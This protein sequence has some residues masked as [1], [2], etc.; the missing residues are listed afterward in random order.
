[1]PWLLCYPPGLALLGLAL[2]TLGW[3]GQRI[4]DHPWCRR[5]RFDLFGVTEPA[6][7]PECGSDLRPGASSPRGQRWRWRWGCRPIR[8]GQ[9]RRNRVLIAAGLLLL[10]GSGGMGY[11]VVRHATAIGFNWNSLKPAWLLIAE[12]R[13]SQK[14]TVDRA[15][16]EIDRR[17]TAK[18][19]SP[20]VAARLIEHALNTQ[21]DPKIAWD[22]RWGTFIE[23]AR[24]GSLRSDGD[25]TRYATQALASVKAEVYVKPSIA[26]P[27]Q[28]IVGLLISGGRVG[29]PPL[30]PPP[31]LA[32]TP[33]VTPN[34]WMDSCHRLGP[35]E[36]ELIEA[37]VGSFPLAFERFRAERDLNDPR[38]DRIAIGLLRMPDLAPGPVSIRARW[39][40][41]LLDA[42][43]SRRIWAEEVREFDVVGQAGPRG[44][45]HL[46]R[47]SQGP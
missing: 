7:C 1:M 44:I 3:R 37:W 38:L 40:L 27:G 5:C 47:S 15:F 30:A 29:G 14:A 10:L 18:T 41:R 17:L 33:I 45:E 32:V 22:A 24:D 35:I 36:V 13:S 28:S 20:R 39:R 6:A 42:C 25:W 9:R 19:L 46:P 8:I 23:L 31:L 34:T 4:D 2:F 43:S 26:H 16:A 11:G 21:A 12:S